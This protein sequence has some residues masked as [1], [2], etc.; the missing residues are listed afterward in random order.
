M[1][2]IGTSPNNY[3]APITGSM[4]VDIDILA[5]LDWTTDPPT[6]EGW[7]WVQRIGND[8]IEIVQFWNIGG[9]FQTTDFE[10]VNG[11]THWLGPLPVPE[12]PKG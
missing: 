5:K 8:S 10:G 2:W 9:T 1:Y 7:Y 12:I 3:P 4:K 6:E 11:F